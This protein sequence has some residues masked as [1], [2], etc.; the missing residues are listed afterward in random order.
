M[1]MQ[2]G[3]TSRAGLLNNPWAQMALTAIVIVILI[4]LAAK[5]LW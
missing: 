1:N 4:A 3:H 5:Y 2:S